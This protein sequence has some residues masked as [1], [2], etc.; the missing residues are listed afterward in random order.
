MVTARPLKDK[1]WAVGLFNRGDA[2]AKM[3]VKWSDLGLV[4]NLR[5]HDLWAQRDLG[6]LAE[7]FFADVPSHGVVLIEVKW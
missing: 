6:K 2:K 4:G 5:V 3:G 1:T 7:Q